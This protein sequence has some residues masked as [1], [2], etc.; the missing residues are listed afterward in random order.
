MNKKLIAIFLISI[1]CLA[2][3]SISIAAE[4]K[5]NLDV[6]RNTSEVI[7][8]Y[9]DEK[10]G[11]STKEVVVQ[12]EIS[13]ANGPSNSKFSNT[14]SEATTQSSA[15]ALSYA[16]NG[17]SYSSFLMKATGWAETWIVAAVSGNPCPNWTL[18]VNG[19]FWKNGSLYSTL[20]SEEGYTVWKVRT[21]KEDW[22]AAP[23][24]DYE[25]ESFHRI[26]DYNGT[27]IW[28]K[29]LYGDRTI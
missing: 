10:T 26:Y 14:T 7:N 18:H 22:S 13:G 3:F 11:E 17:I 1:M 23:G 20:P 9:A 8:F 16:A 21:D 15:V 27:K 29:T 12:E 24:T 28:D 25:V 2:Q 5:E 6:K 4:S 19:N